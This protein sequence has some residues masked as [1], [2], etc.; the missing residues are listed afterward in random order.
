MKNEIKSDFYVLFDLRY[1]HK[2][3]KSTLIIV[4]QC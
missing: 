1:L 4:T 2:F 3:H